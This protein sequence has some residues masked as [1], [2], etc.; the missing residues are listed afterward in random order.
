MYTQHHG[1]SFLGAKA[2]F[3]NFSPYAAGS[4][5]LGNFFQYVVVRIPEEGQTACESVNVHTGFDSSFYISDAVGDGESDFL[6]SGGT[7][8]TDVVTGNGDG[9]PFRNVFGAILKNV[10]DQTHGRF[11]RENVGAA[12]SVFF[13]NIVLNG[14]AQ[15]VGRNAL[16]LGNGDVHAE[17]YG[18]RSVDG[19]GSGNFVQSDLV[20]QDFHISQGVDSY[21]YFTNF[22][23]GHR[24]GGVITNLG[25]QVECA[26]QAAATVS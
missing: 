1:F 8:F 10:G 7:S 21:A 6:G 16:F 11:R 18:S 17:Q 5:E 12:G 26:G 20:K 25:R 9:V 15:C 2:F 22:A 24:I 19:H 3:H 13:Q 23:F 14:A 4:T